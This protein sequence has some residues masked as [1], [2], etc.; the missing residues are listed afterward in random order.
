MYLRTVSP[1]RGGLWL[2]A[3]IN[4]NDQR[5]YPFPASGLR[6]AGA[7]FNY[8]LIII[9][10][11]TYSNLFTKQFTAAQPMYRRR[12]PVNETG[13]GANGNGSETIRPRKSH[14]Y[15]PEDASSI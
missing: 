15:P 8:I 4:S 13:A 6:L 5:R 7:A 12:R 9:Q 2:G 3:H 10:S 1:S 11:Y 14:N